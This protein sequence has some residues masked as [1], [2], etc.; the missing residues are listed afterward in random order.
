VVEV[1]QAGIRTDEDYIELPRHLSGLSG[2]LI[3]ESCIR[4]R[5]RALSEEIS[6][7]IG[8]KVHCVVVLSGAAVFFSDLARACSAGNICHLL[9]I[10]LSSYERCIQ[11][12]DG[13]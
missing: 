7:S 8:K 3:T 11:K 2:I 10:K 6:R 12:R 1:P 4:A 5:V 13:S 9:V